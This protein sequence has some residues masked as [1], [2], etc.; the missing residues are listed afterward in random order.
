MRRLLPRLV[1]LLST[2]LLLAQAQAPEA[3]QQ[4][5]S[6]APIIVEKNVAVPMRDH[7]VLR[8][9]V[10]RPPGNGRFPTLVY[11]T[12]YGK[13][14]ALAGYS[15]FRHAAERGYAVVAED[16]RGRYA[17]A[18]EFSAYRNEGD[19][20]YDTIEWAARQSWSDGNIGTFGLSYPGA[21][22]W[23]AAVE[24]PPHLK[25]MVPAMTFSTPRQFFYSSGVWDMSWIDWIW[26][27]IAPDTREKKGLPGPATS[28]QAIAEWQ[29][30]H[31]SF[32]RAL[33]LKSLDVLAEVAPYYNEWLSHPPD[34]P[35]WNWAEL[36]D[37]YARVDAAVLNLSGWYDEDYGP[38]GATTNFLGLL[39]SRRSAGDPR[40]QLMLGPWIHGVEETGITHSGD[41][42]FGPSARI[43]YDEVVLGWMDHYLRGV[44]N[45]VDRQAAVRL[46]VMGDNRWRDESSWPPPA[47][48][49][50]S[51][52]LA[53][54]E[55]NTR[56]KLQPVAPAGEQ[57]SVFTSD[58]ANP[59]LDPYAHQL[60][61][62]DYR[63]LARRSDVLVFE[64]ERLE[65]DV[66][67]LGPVTVEVYAAC[68]C[69]DFDLWTRLLDVGPDGTAFNLMSP[70]SDVLRASYRDPER[71]SL[72]KPGEV[73][74]LVLSNMRTGNVFKAGH[75][76]RVQVSASFFPDFS[77]NLQS[78]ELESNSA[79]TR[80]ATIRIYHGAERASRLVLPVIPR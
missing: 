45:G 35:W 40:T 50:T 18:G 33:P 32:A 34:D 49:S 48:R 21:V 7:V 68:D 47:A 38:E 54:G 20:G 55:K 53:G 9:D 52:Y 43:D 77:R 67:A 56:G 25:A 8:A 63:D 16:V 69:P 58:P 79:K 28:Q 73:Y 42:E 66:E 19:D 60:G 29:Q 37:K 57:V 22:Q 71:R 31:E 46:F 24:G 76:I 15:I 41:R 5:R 6:D 13:H 11:R 70:G 14:K 64:T 75:R 65:R 78:G 59:V 39:A 51:F 27:N 30:K 44:A 17:S 26:D 74:K 2:T 1:F 80:V 10:L 3:P 4:P 23:L 62:H 12:P 61:A 72:L 36:R